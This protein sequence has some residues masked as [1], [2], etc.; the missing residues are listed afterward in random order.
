[1]SS[2]LR[3][4]R[5]YGYLIAIAATVAAVVVTYLLKPWV[6]PGLISPFLLAV[7]LVAMY[8][9]KGP[10]WFATLLGVLILNFWLLPAPK[11]R[12]SADLVRQV[13]VVVVAGVLVQLGGSLYGQR[14]RAV[15]EAQENQRLRAAAE[16]AATEAEEAATEAEAA[17]VEAA[18]AAHRAEE[19]SARA[20][21]A[22]S[23]LRDTQGQLADFFD[24]ASTPLHWATED[25]TIIRTNQ[26]ELDMLGYDREEYIGRN[27]AEFYVDQTVIEDVMRR[28]V[29]GEVVRQCPAR[30]RAKSGEIRDVVLDSS[31]YFRDGEF[32]HTRCFTR[33]VTAELQARDAAERLAAIVLSSSDAIL[34]KTLEGVITSWNPAAERIFGYS[35]AEMVGDTV[36]RLVPPEHHQAERDLLDRVR[37]GERVEVTEVERVTKDGRRIWISLSVSPIRDAAGVIAG[38]ASIKRDITERKLLDERL[39]NAQR[40][41]A[42]G[43]LAGGI[44]HEANNQMSVVLGGAHFLLKRT[45]LAD[46]ARTDIEQIRQAAE[47]TA[48]I[49]QQLLAFGRRQMLQLREVNLNDVV[50]S[51]GPVL[52]RSLSEDHRLN[53]RLGLLDGV[54]RADPRQLEQ[55][56]LNLTLNARD[57]MPQ[58][59]QLTIETFELEVSPAEG[60]RTG[61]L[62][63][64]YEALVV[65]DTGTGMDQT[66]QQR[67]FEPFFTTKPTGE[68]TGLGLSVVEGIVSQV[69]GHIRVESSPGHGSRFTLYFPQ[70]VAALHPEPPPD[71]EPQVHRPGAMILV[72]ED[73]AR[74]RAMATRALSDAGYEV[75]EA[76]DASAAMDLIRRRPGQLDLV[77]T[78]IGM[79]GMDG[80]ALA[81]RLHEARPG[82]PVI[83]MTGYGERDEEANSP[84]EPGL[85]IHKPFAPAALVRAVGE[86]LAAEAGEVA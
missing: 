15:H 41:Q 37:K 22:E 9:G 63:G 11:E 29:A 35:A 57:A 52:R 55:V 7:A 84:V 5:I 66:T 45:D 74:V 20:R 78:D 80:Y 48:A 81:R 28:L 31:G 65:S 75:L 77:L 82:L 58:G 56:L 39:R 25:G 83:F 34:G 43:Q 30:L 27:I 42:V 61:M 17:S 2:D 47:R 14:Q 73:D 51:I 54:V 16:D 19:E 6:G 8:A 71:A 86:T 12:T 44:A 38:A 4:R 64:P 69:G 10:G 59:G 53:V 18:E 33:D 13:L 46:A 70:L 68:G 50:Q 40:L 1:M 76:E 79:P 85:V 26:A 36:F 3:A 72:V 21:E 62:P 49:T 32:V 67:M 24:T 23:A 60:A